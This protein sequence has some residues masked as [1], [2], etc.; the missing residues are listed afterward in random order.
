M[1]KKKKTHWLDE[2]PK[3]PYI[4]ALV[5][6]IITVITSLAAGGSI[7]AVDA[8]F[9]FLGNEH[10]HRIFIYV[11]GGFNI[12]GWTANMFYHFRSKW[13]LRYIIGATLLQGIIGVTML[14]W[15]SWSLPGWHGLIP[16]IILYFIAVF[17]PII[18][19]GFSRFLA[20][21]NYSPKTKTGRWLNKFALLLGGSAMGGVWLS[22]FLQR[23]GAVSGFSIWGALG[24]LYI[25]WTTQANVHNAWEDRKKEKL[26]MGKQ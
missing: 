14:N 10:F 8:D 15:V 5:G 18:N 22:K 12:I 21:E 6:I 11:S 1:K 9:Q 2:A 3:N 23:T 17:L 7:P 13:W 26:A 20:K 25:I 19:E 24:Y 16:F 4:K